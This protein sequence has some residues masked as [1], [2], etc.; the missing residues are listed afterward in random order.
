MLDLILNFVSCSRASGLRISSSEVLDCVN[1]LE[2][3]DVLEEPLFQSVLRSN[4]AKSRREQAHF[5]HLYHLFFHEMR[6]E[7]SIPHA[8]ALQELMEK[9]LDSLNEKLNQD[10]SFQSILDFL[11]GDPLAYL[12]EM[13]QLQSDTDGEAPSGLPN[14]FG[15]LVRRLQI[16]SQINAIGDGIARFMANNRQTINWEDR[17]AMTIHYDERLDSARRMLREDPEPYDAG[18]KRV[19]SYDR[20]LNQLGEKS[21]FS[22]TKKEVEEM[23]DIVEQLVRKLKDTVQRRYSKHKRGVLDIK[24]TLRLSA[25]YQGVPIEVVYKHKPK[26]KGKIVTLCDVSGS[27][28]TAAKFMLNMLYSLQDCFLQVRSFIFV[29]ELEE[30]T[31]TFEKHEINIA[32]DKSLKE[33]DI[34]YQAST[35]Y[36]STFRQFKR[37]YMDILNKKTTLIIVGDGR[38]NYSNPEEKILDEMREKCR[39]IIWLNPESL[40][41]WNT[42]DSRMRTYQ[43]YCNEVRHCQNLDQL[44]DFIKTL[45]L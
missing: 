23:R 19:T 31:Q 44:L 9:T 35:D 11:Q 2:L 24:K 38:T 29:D 40:V 8:N 30:V 17:K 1:Q 12:E 42:G 36:G 13:R 5:D 18:L 26:R 43:R 21:F 28:W 25:K 27:V 4:F 10:P 6:S 20:H 32:V 3:I 41:F 33:A 37:E 14:T 22:L 34:N 45:V 16:M 39:R 15:P 7:L